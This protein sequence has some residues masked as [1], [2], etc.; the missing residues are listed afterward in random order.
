MSTISTC[1]KWSAL[2]PRLARTL[3]FLLLLIGFSE[4]QGQLAMTRTSFAGA[5]VPLTTGGGATTSTAIG[6]DGSQNGIAIGFTFNYLGT[7]F[8]TFN[9]S[10]NGFG[11]FT[12]LAAVSTTNMANNANLYA[13]TTPNNTVAPWWDDLTLGT[14]AILYQTTG[15]APNRV[16]TVQ[17]GNVTSFSSTATATLNFQLKLYETTNV[18]E[19]WYGTYNA[20]TNS[21]LESASIGLENVTGG[22][23]N[24]LDAATGSGR[25]GQGFL[26]AND[27]FMRRNLRFTPGSPTAIA[28]G[29]YT[30]GVGQTYPSLSEA[31]ADLNHRGV[32]GAVTLSLTD[33]NYN[34]TV[35]GGSN[36][37]PILLGPVNGTSAVNTVTI[38][39]A[40]AA[41]AT[42]TVSFDG[43]NSG[44]GINQV[45]TLAYGTSNEPILGAV[46]AQFIAIRRLNLTA[47]AT[48]VV[49]RGIGSINSSG[50]LGT[51]NCG[52]QGITI[53]LN[54]NNL[55]TIGIEL[56][57]ATAPSSALGANSSNAF[58]DLA[59]SNV[60]NGI[61]LNGT[62]TIPDLSNVVGTSVPTLFNSIGS[63]TANDIGGATTVAGIR[64]LNQSGVNCFNNEVRNIFTN[65]GFSVD[66]IFLDN[67]AGTSQ[68]FMN[69][70]HSIRN[71]STTAVNNITGIR[72]NMVTVGTPTI[73]VYNNFVSNL[74]SGYTGAASATRQVKGIFLQS[75]AF[76]PSGAFFHTDF[77]N[78]RLDGSANP[79]ISNVCY[80]IGTSTGPTMNA[81]NNVF[82]NFTGAQTGTA[83]HYCYRTPAGN[84]VGPAGSVSNFND[85]YL[86][87]TTNGF[88]GMANI[89]DLATLANWQATI[90]GQDVAS[91]STDPGYISA[92][93]LHV[94]SAAINNLGNMTGITWV[95]VDIDNAVRGGPPDI[96]ADEFTPSPIDLAVQTF[97]SP[98]SGNCYTSTQQVTVRLRNNGT[99][100]HSFVTNNTTLTVNVT[101]A[102]VATISTTVNSNAVN[103]GVPVPVNAT[104]DIPVGVINMSAAGTYNFQTYHSTAGD[105]V[106]GN[107]TLSGY[108]ITY[109]PG[110]ASPATTNMCLGDTRTVTATGNTASTVQWQQSTDGGATWTNIAGATTPSASISPLDT[111]LVRMLMCGSLATNNILVNVAVTTPP[112]TVNDTVCG[113]GPV[114]LS[115]TGAG[116]L[117]W[118]TAPAGGQSFFTGSPYNTTVFNTTTYYVSSVQGGGNESVG[119]LNNSAG[120][121]QQ[122]STAYNTFNVTTPCTLVGV[123]VYPGAAGTARLEVR[124]NLGALVAGPWALTVTAAQVNTPVFF[125]INWQM[126]VGTNFRMA[127]AAGSVSM[128]RNTLGVSYPYCSPSNSVCITGSSAGATFY[129]FA[130]NWQI[131]CG[132][133]S[134]RTPVTA[135][136][137]PAPPITITPPGGNLCENDTM[138]IVVTSPNTNYT[139]DWTPGTALSDSTNDTL[140]AYPSS[141]T[142]YILHA[143]DP[144][145]TCNL[146]DTIT[147]QVN[148][149]PVGALWW[150]DTLICITDTVQMDFDAP[151]SEFSDSTTVNI[152]DPPAPAAVSTITV[153]GG[154]TALTATGLQQVCLD[155]TH[156]WDSDINITLR[157]PAGTLFDL[158]SGN[159]GSGDNYTNTCFQMGAATNITAGFAP[160]TGNW[161]PEGAGGFASFTGQNANGNW[162]LRVQ[163]FFG[164]DIGTINWWSMTFEAPTLSYSWVSDPPGFTASTDSVNVAP[165]TTTTYTLT[166]TNTGTG[167]TSDFVHTVQVHPPLSVDIFGPTLICDGDPV[168]LTSIATGGNGTI[169]YDW[170]GLGNGDTLDVIVTS[171]T[172]YYLTVTDGCQTPAATDSIFIQA[173]GPLFATAS[174]DTIICEG[175]TLTLG[176]NASGGNFVYD[177]GWSTGDSTSSITVTPPA[178]LTYTVTVTDGCNHVVVDPVNVT[179][180]PIEQAGFSFTPTFPQPGQVV[181][182]TNTSINGVS[183]LWTFGDGSPPSNLQNPTHSY[184]PAGNYTVTLIVTGPCGSDTMVQFITIFTGV[185]DQLDGG[186]VFMYPNPNNG[187]FNVALSN[188]EGKEVY[189]NV[190]DLRG[191]E[192]ARKVLQVNSPE[193]REAFDLTNVTK[194]IYFVRVATERGTATGKI[195]IE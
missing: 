83:K 88:V 12:S 48:S 130:Y 1:F 9:V 101:G 192:V 158:S 90:T 54:R 80:E 68:I 17:W 41:P 72:A 70:V 120:G 137:T 184:N 171:D 89:T 31:V 71:L 43:S 26:S 35:A 178:S 21:T 181:T 59:I 82:A 102:I 13:V 153:A 50:T 37:F 36:W 85:L 51:Q 151:A 179:V 131:S 141:T 146:Y 148:P 61:F 164:G 100:P 74:L 160:F 104:V 191:I 55:N 174:N 66:G 125:P 47:S 87:N 53:A 129:Y 194:G 81:R 42:A 45:S 111:V 94:T 103:G 180:L 58:L 119:L 118:F 112:V 176:V 115:A 138:N 77:N 78:V 169:N 91:V 39:P 106:L 128:F 145:T 23:N 3:A 109:Q 132:C 24:Y 143:V 193:F 67:A 168:T 185:L 64:L 46:G 99:T 57:T 65:G 117:Q 96:G 27:R 187:E 4:V 113:A 49:D 69:K 159:G 8:T 33:A 154:P 28:A 62:S 86:A 121:G 188:L 162:E 76:G 10:T 5:Y 183:Y 155:I 133:S 6:N 52:Y 116:S 93:N 56:R 40:A 19:F 173:A 147:I 44:F 92:T 2:A 190:F 34:T 32:A 73:R 38:Q 123:T 149:A 97:V 167:C 166:V 95:T 75:T 157:S 165:D 124:D 140:N 110:T 107:D 114:S 126:V 156:T 122:T 105:P 14:G 172:T 177:Y 108:T 30:V 186:E 60:A 134:S 182:F 25:T 139:W 79:N 195:I 163:D 150:S 161:I 175:G 20:G 7:N 63:A 22:N 11:S 84:A 135:V 15:A 189:I 142:T 170:N 29:T 127:Q 144:A 18:I 136:V 16:F 152:L 98:T